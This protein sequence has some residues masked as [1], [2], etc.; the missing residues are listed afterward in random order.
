M[1][2]KVS[3]ETHYNVKRDSL[4]ASILLV[5]AMY[6]KVSKETHYNVQ[7]D[8][9]ASILLVVAIYSKV[10]KETY[11]HVKRDLVASS[12]DNDS[13]TLSA[14]PEEF[15]KPARAMRLASFEFEACD[16][17]HARPSPFCRCVNS[18]K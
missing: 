7:R 4:V 2:S 1:Y 14:K 18:E 9:V 16:L 12:K 15:A 5:V 11:Y 8:L 17:A 6:S 3:K 13:M 10:S